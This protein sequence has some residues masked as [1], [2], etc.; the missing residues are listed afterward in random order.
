MPKK[1]GVLFA[2]RSCL[3]ITLTNLVTLSFIALCC[4]IISKLILCP[5]SFSS[6]VRLISFSKP[7]CQTCRIKPLLF[8]LGWGWRSW[9][10]C[11]DGPQWNWI[12]WYAGDFF[13]ISLVEHISFRTILRKIGEIKILFNLGVFTMDFIFHVPYDSPMLKT[14]CFYSASWKLIFLEFI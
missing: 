13:V 3:Y 2:L 14:L 7:S 9:S 4:F 6:K 10:F 5:P 12:W 11:K 1:T 8:R